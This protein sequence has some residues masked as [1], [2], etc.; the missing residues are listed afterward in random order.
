MGRENPFTILPKKKLDSTQK[1]FRT[2]ILDKEFFLR[3]CKE[4][5]L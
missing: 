3:F 5:E 1:P 2:H 4:V